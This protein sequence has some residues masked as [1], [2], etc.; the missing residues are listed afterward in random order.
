MPLVKSINFALSFRKNVE[1]EKQKVFDLNDWL[2]RYVA[3]ADLKIQDA[4]NLGASLRR[5]LALVKLTN[6][7]IL[8]LHQ[9][10]R[11]DA[12]VLFVLNGR[13]PEGLTVRDLIRVNHDSYYH[14]IMATYTEKVRSA[15]KRG[16]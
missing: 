7:Q 6:D 10:C 15:A 11:D 8:V 9:V 2:G 1:E 16:I 5:E 14:G 13:L 12:N 4:V 3:R